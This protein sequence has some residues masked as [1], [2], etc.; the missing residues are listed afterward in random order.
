[1]NKLKQ[2]S[3]DY[4]EDTNI[5]DNDEDIESESEYNKWKQR[6]LNRLKRDRFLLI[7]KEKS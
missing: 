2:E 6:E 7:D 4:N 3:W 1:M 5:D